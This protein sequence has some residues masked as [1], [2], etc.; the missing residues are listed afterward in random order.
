MSLRAENRTKPKTMV[1]TI[2]LIWEQFAPYHVD[3]IEAVGRRLAGQVEVVAVEVATTSQT[4]EWKPSGGV[5]HARKLTLFPG[6]SYDRI[7][8]L[9]RFWRHW[10]ALKHCDVVFVGISYAHPDII[11]LSWLLRLRG[12]KTVMI[13][14]S[15]FDDM[16]RLAVREW[17]KSLLLK[18][19]S[20]AIVAGRRQREF[21]RMLGFGNRPILPGCD[22][23]GVKRIRQEAG[24]AADCLYEQ[25]NFICVARFV[26]KKN[27]F[28][29]I[30][31]Y[32][33]YVALAAGS[34]RKLVLAGSGPLEERLRAYCDAKNLSDLVEFT[35]FLD[36]VQVSRRLAASLALILI[37]TEE[38][39]GLVVNEAVALGIPVIVSH[40]VGAGDS[41][42]R[43]LINGFVFEAAASE[44]PARAMVALA[45]DKVRWQR[46]AQASA[47]RAW[48][49]DSERFA[50]AVEAMVLPAQAEAA[51]ASISRYEAVLAQTA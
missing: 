3:R 33:R 28:G 14:D 47:D 35:G 15:K 39:W 36:S 34:P 9:R 49:A 29:L 18:S 48:L 13:T 23:V 31:G 8:P 25:R 27:L 46:M 7:H 16:P 4:Y 6:Q 21:V 17:G 19:Y 50:D 51:R 1:T 5:A 42:V 30:D 12:C 26:A 45:S 37:S 32:A 22:T 2:A 43:N 40:A 10:H 44:G 24:D 20:A 38:Q 11:A 41:L